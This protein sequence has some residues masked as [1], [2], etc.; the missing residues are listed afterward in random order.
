ML[1]PYQEAAVA[2]LRERLLAGVRR[3]IVYMPTG[4]GK[5]VLAAFLTGSA[6][7][8]GKRVIFAVPALSLIDQTVARF[9]ANGV[10][11]IGVMQGLHELTRFGEPV[12]VCS[13]QTLARRK[14][15]DVDLVIIDEAHM[16][17]KFVRE[18][19]A[20]PAWAN[21]PFVGLTAT[22]WAKGMAKDWEELLVATTMRELIDLG[23]LCDFRAFAP[24]H[25]NLAGVK[26]VAGDYDLAQLAVAMDKGQLVADIVSTW[27][28]RGENR[29]TICFCVNRAHANHVQ[30]QFA[31]MGVSAAYMDA[32]TKREDRNAI[33]AR[34][35]AGEVRVI[36]NVGVLTTGFDSDVRCIIL[37]RPTK[38]E[39]LYVQM[40]G[41]GL[42]PAEGK[43]ACLIL[44]H[45]DNT[46]R[47]GF[48][49]DIHHDALDDG[50][51]KK[52]S[53]AE[54]KEPLPK[55]CPRCACLRPPKTPVC[56]SCGFK[57]EIVSNVEA[58]A[59][60]LHEITRD[61]RVKP[62]DW[63]MEQKGLFYSELVLH[64]QLRGYKAGWAY[65]AY[66]HRLGVG[67]PSTLSAR[68]AKA[69]RAETQS[70]V[71][72]YAIAKAKARQKSEGVGY[73]VQG[74]V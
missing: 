3:I 43:Q 64:S 11:E 60:D 58:V 17:F 4:A 18:W 52:K 71:R 5:T 31:A 22:P 34:F 54:K 45:S 59:G 55:E 44:D 50:A 19:M 73:G 32:K 36:C 24:A 25:P 21:I 47:L 27:L 16:Q 26:T 23:H 30:Q 74:R 61:R 49:T 42:R 57:A 65:H 72:S 13:I 56:P 67:P 39:I 6:R 62:R 2:R 68:P 28:E 66:K 40:I 51:P 1:R 29:P 69:I 41:R 20:D 35:E 48:V 8:K 70:W 12:Q 63:T 53:A 33:I 7:A 38:S 10:T 46:L 37:A 9:E 15:P 14:I